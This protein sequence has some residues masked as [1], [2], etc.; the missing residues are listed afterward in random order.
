MVCLTPSLPCAVHVA[1]FVLANDGSAFL[2]AAYNLP[3]APQ[4][5]QKVNSF[6]IQP[7]SRS[8]SKKQCLQM[9]SM[10]MSRLPD[11]AY[12][13]S[14]QALEMDLDLPPPPPPSPSHG[15]VDGLCTID[16]PFW[17]S[18]ADS[19]CP[20]DH[21]LS[22]KESAALHPSALPIRVSSMPPL[23]HNA[24]CA[25]L[26]PP[27]TVAVKV[28]LAAG[29]FKACPR[30]KLTGK[31]RVTTP[32]SI[33][34]TSHP[35][36]SNIITELPRPLLTTLSS[37]VH[38]SSVMPGKASDKTCSRPRVRSLLNGRQI[39]S[40]ITTL[41]SA[42]PRELYSAQATVSEQSQARSGSLSSTDSGDSCPKDDIRSHFSD[43]EDEEKSMSKKVFFGESQARRNRRFRQRLSDTLACLSCS[44]D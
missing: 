13:H 14:S 10:I 38:K 39:S 3:S 23:N 4:I 2:S 1:Y 29:A 17:L 34:K 19:T 33:C 15:N 22:P 11:S 16:E 42:C 25:N 26:N 5:S 43:S 37:H 40:P 31:R 20:T 24:R 7:S 30:K 36:P 32:S 27:E 8:Q 35:S 41:S 21:I 9:A 18:F 6:D 44:S 28:P 12:P